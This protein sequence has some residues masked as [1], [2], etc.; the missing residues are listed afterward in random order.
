MT[1]PD[2]TGS[3]LTAVLAA[4]VSVS[5]QSPSNIALVKYW[6]KKGRQLPV[7]PS[8][9]MTLSGAH[10]IT[11]LTALPRETEGNVNLDFWFEGKQNP[12][13]GERMRKFADSITDIFPWLQQVNLKLETQNTFPH[14]AGIA[15]SASAFSALALCLCSLD[16]ELSGII[17]EESEFRSKASYVARLGS[18]SACRSLFPGFT[19]WGASKALKGSSDLLAVPVPDVHPVFETLHDSIIIVNRG[20]KPVSSSEG[21]DRMIGHPFAEARVKQ[22][23]KNTAKLLEALK[24]GDKQTF[25]RIT[26]NEAFTLHALMMTS[27]DGFMLMEPETVRIISHLQQAR[28]ESGLHVCFTLDAGPNIHILYFE[29]EFEQVNK[30]IVEDLLKNNKQ[31]QVLNDFYGS[32]PVKMG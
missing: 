30:L 23:H 19:V 13:F 31:N 32:G 18:G 8:L 22:A 4:P 17:L 1:T 9:S 16:S 6:G 20:E 14:S 27:A 10:T 3:R 2:L 15:S 5:W 29:D 25:M 21:H 26:E 24:T 28:K 12:A 7:N 11:T